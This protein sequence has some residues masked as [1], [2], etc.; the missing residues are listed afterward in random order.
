MIIIIIINSL[1]IPIG[2][3]G[4]GSS[5]TRVEKLLKEYVNT[6][7]TLIGKVLTRQKA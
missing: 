3:G 2:G 4:G 7:R 6:K 1:L 5:L